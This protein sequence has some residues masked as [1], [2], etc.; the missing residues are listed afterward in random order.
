MSLLGIYQASSK[1]FGCFPP[2]GAEGLESDLV[3]Q[4]R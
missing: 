4:P 3:V 1:G 2:E